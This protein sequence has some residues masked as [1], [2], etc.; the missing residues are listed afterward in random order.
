[1][2]SSK[3]PSLFRC[4]FGKI[5]AS[6]CAGIA[7]GLSWRCTPPLHQSRA[8]A[9]QRMQSNA[10]ACGRVTTLKTTSPLAQAR[11]Q[12]VVLPL[13][14]RL[15]V[16]AREAPQVL[17]AHRL[18]HRRAAPDALAVVVRLRAHMQLIS[19]PR[20]AQHLPNSAA[21]Q[22]KENA[23]FGTCAVIAFRPLLTAWLARQ[24]HVSL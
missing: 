14:L 11:L 9:P 15:E 1:M 23:F 6:A 20:S 2:N 7:Y 22:S 3:S 24:Q 10:C 5:K 16:Q 21:Q 4:S 13:L 18:V 17:A 19:T 12:V 8:A